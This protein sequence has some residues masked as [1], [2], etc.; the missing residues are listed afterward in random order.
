MKNFLAIDT[1]S[2]YMTVAAC[3]DNKTYLSH[4]TDCAMRHSTLLMQEVDELLARANA[5][6]GDFDFFAA[7]VGAGSFTG[8][9]IGIST[10]KGF[11]LATGKPTLPVTS[12]EL[13]AYTVGREKGGKILVLCD[14]L[15]GNYYAA[16][17]EN[18]T[19][20]LQ[21]SYLNEE[22]VLALIKRDG[23]LPVCA[24]PLDIGGVC[25]ETFDPA[26]GLV[27]AVIAL[28]EKGAFAPLD[29]LYIRKSSAELNLEQGAKAK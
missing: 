1:G 16:G 24:Q 8:I 5:K 28:E 21:P 6:I 17:Y 9:R 14:A 26:Q 2:S 4:R 29:A 3:V 13:G 27:Q 25:A 10:A 20:V 7:M 15:H 11:A 18:D 19:L 22:E 23:F 12:F